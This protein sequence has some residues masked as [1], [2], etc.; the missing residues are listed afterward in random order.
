MFKTKIKTYE[1]VMVYEDGKLIDVLGTGYHRISSKYSKYT[2][3]TLSRLTVSNMALILKNEKL[4]N[5]VDVVEVGA[6]QV[7]LI[8][9]DN[10]L[11]EVLQEGLYA[12]WKEPVEYSFDIKDMSEVKVDEDLSKSVIR[13]LVILGLIHKIEVK[14]FE[15]G[16]LY[17]DGVFKEEL[18]S[19]VHYFWKNPV[20]VQ[21]EILDNRQQIIELGGQ[22]ILT[23]DKANL[24]IN[25][26]AVYKVVN[27]KIATQ[28][29]K[30]FVKQ[31]YTILQMKLRSYV[32]E[33]SFDEL[34]ANKSNVGNYILDSSKEECKNLGIELVSCGIKDIILP[35]D[36]KEIM[37]QVLVAEKKAAASMIMRR[38]ETAATRSMMNTAKLMN[39][40]QM[41]YKLKEMEFVEKV[42]DKIG[43]ITVSGN[44]GMVSQLKEIFGSSQ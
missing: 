29:N 36:I 38:E 1:K 41:L 2:V 37:N 30:D 11:D 28:E 33:F 16:I 4:L 3:S 20:Q 39:D 18:N 34:L 8:Y 35:G 24:R 5:E 9:K 21:V 27:A 43:E 15:K 17:C 23:K 40:N 6:D 13:E 19:G 22:E 12:F 31:L 14:H 10:I 26:D 25:F 7:A 42:A 32:G 44:G